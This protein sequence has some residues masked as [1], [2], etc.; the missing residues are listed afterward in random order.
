MVYNELCGIGDG[1]KSEFYTKKSFFETSIQVFCT[2]KKY[3]ADK[4]SEKCFVLVGY[5]PSYGEEVRVTYRS[6]E[7]M[8]FDITNKDWTEMINT[9]Y[10]NI[11]SINDK[12]SDRPIIFEKKD[13]IKKYIDRM[14]YFLSDEE[15][16][17]LYMHT[18][19][20][21]DIE[22]IAYVFGKKK[23]SLVVKYDRIIEKI[24]LQENIIKLEYDNSRAICVK[25]LYELGIEMKKISQIL[26]ENYENIKKIIQRKRDK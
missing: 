21:V 25:Y 24:F 22:Q 8:N 19:S 2:G 17:M 14:N 16:S 7:G 15:I 1:D 5:V 26:D 20:N 18:V 9:V 13:F 4:I 11:L 6:N 10:Y 23:D 12:I 3:I